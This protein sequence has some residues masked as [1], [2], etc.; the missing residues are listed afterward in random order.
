MSDIDVS[1]Q[2]DS[3]ENG[4]VR[5]TIILEDD[6]KEALTEV[7]E[8][9]DKLIRVFSGIERLYDFRF[10][11]PDCYIEEENAKEK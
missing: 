6:P 4:K 11:C 10:K 3:A 8:K 5:F 7:C 1:W 9:H 2:V